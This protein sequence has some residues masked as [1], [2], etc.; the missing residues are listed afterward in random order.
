MTGQCTKCIPLTCCEIHKS[1]ADCQTA[2][3]VCSPGKEGWGDWA[4]SCL[5]LR[6]NPVEDRTDET[7]S[8]KGELHV[9]IIPMANKHNIITVGDTQ[10]NTDSKPLPR[11][12]NSCWWE[13]WISDGH[14]DWFQLQVF[15]SVINTMKKTCVE[16]GLCCWPWSFWKT[17]EHPVNWRGNDEIF[18]NRLHWAS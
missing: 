10:R 17:K 4:P 6:N 15:F 3:P 14:T 2:H 13:E 18:R 8:R 5:A 1:L 11:Y 16:T 7:L 12:N 9:K